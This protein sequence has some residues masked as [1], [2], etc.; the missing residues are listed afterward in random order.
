MTEIPPEAAGS[1][2][3]PVP[4]PRARDDSPFVVPRCNF[5]N[6]LWQFDPECNPVHHRK[7]DCCPLHNGSQGALWAVY[8]ELYAR[9][10]DPDNRDYFWDAMLG[11]V[12]ET[13]PAY[14][15]QRRAAPGRRREA[16]KVAVLVAMGIV[17][18]LIF[19]LGACLCA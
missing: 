8:R 4:P 6:H 2:F 18:A 13:V 10:G 12:T 14:R 15:T 7:F 5:E 3:L 11:Q 19:M 1:F 9:A 17:V 16:G